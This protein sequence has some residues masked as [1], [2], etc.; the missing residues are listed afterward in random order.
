MSNMAEW[1]GTNMTPFQNA[2]RILMVGMFTKD[3]ELER[4][5]DEK[6]LSL[7][8]VEDY[9]YGKA[10]AM[11]TGNRYYASDDEVAGWVV[12]CIN[13]IEIPKKKQ[14]ENKEEENGE[15][16]EADDMPKEASK[17][18]AQAKKKEKAEVDDG[19]VQLSLFDL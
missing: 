17:K 10:K 8:N 13:G 11:A 9:V 18:P 1:Q 5:F 6:K 15:M 4:K 19:S 7:K 3:G 12:D 16:L 14:T 2:L